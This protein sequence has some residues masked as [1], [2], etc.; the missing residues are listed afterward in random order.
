MKPS[1]L[2]RLWTIKW[3]SLTSLFNWLKNKQTK[4]KQQKKYSLIGFDDHFLNQENL[5]CLQLRSFSILRLECGR[6]FVVVVI[7][8]FQH[9]LHFFANSYFVNTKHKLQIVQIASFYCTA[10]ATSQYVS[11]KLNQSLQYIFLPFCQSNW[12]HKIKTKV[13]LVMRF[14]TFIPLLKFAFAYAYEIHVLHCMKGS[15]NF[16]QQI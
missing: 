10:G 11:Q 9:L 16:W 15:K 8:L 5:E 1:F 3:F 2:Q 14:E 4:Q 7:F 13:I 12:M 6:K